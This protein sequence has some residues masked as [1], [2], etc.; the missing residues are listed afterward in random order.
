MNLIKQTGYFS[1]VHPLVACSTHVY[2]YFCNF[3]DPLSLFSAQ[4]LTK[5]FGFH[6]RD[7]CN[8]T[9]LEEFV[10]IADRNVSQ[11][12]QE[13]ICKSSSDW[14]N[15][16]QSHFLSNLDFLKPIRVSLSIESN[17]LTSCSFNIPMKNT[18]FILF[19]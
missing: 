7:L 19:S 8:S 6:L 17:T 14:L 18:T 10:H 9:P 5:G 3:S 1:V 4:V 2:S 15:K 13:I 16:A 12:T 11:L